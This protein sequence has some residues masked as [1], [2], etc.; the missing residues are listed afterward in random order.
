VRPGRLVS[1]PAYL[2]GLSGL[3]PYTS[4]SNALRREIL[5]HP[6]ALRE[7][8]YD[9]RLSISDA[10]TE[11]VP[12][13][14]AHLERWRSHPDGSREAQLTF[15]CHS[16]GGLVA[17][18][19]AEATEAG[20]ALSRSIRR[21]VTLGTPYYGSVKAFRAL[22]TGRAGPL[23]VH[24]R[25]LRPVLL[26]MPSL[27]E[28]SPRYRCVQDGADLR[29]LTET[30]FAA[31]GGDGDLAAKADW[32]HDNLNSHV[33]AAGRRSCPVRAR[34][35]TSQPTLQTFSFDAGHPR[36]DDPA[37]YLIEGKDWQGDGTVYR[38]SAT[39]AGAEPDYIPQRH[40]RLASTHEGIEY[41]RAVLTESPTGPPLAAGEGVGIDFPDSVMLGKPFQIQ[42]VADPWARV[43]CVARD[44]STGRQVARA[45]IARSSD[46]LSAHLVLRSPGLYRIEAK[47]GGG[48]AVGDYVM[49]YQDDM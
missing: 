29:K 42:I 19:F 13:A 20:Q 33:E 18:Y 5:A 39:P 31:I 44:A 47:S 30:D 27:Y 38:Q 23:I 11:L 37:C 45:Q 21:I 36:F 22:A 8:S 3:D 46:A 35:G 9:W 16:M 28:L 1:K 17:R 15:V 7:F 41:V 26:S 32:V 4:L 14:K 12:V 49:V 2:P 6:D 43:T 48:S 10:A 34:V 24:V 25:R 40:G